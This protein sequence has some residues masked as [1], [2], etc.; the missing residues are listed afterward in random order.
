MAMTGC[1]PIVYGARYEK[2]SRQNVSDA[3]PA[4][5]EVGRTTMADV[6]LTLGD[7]DT[8]AADESW[9]AYVSTYREGGGGAVLILG[10][11]GQ[12]GMLGGASKQM[13]YRR[14]LVRFDGAGLVKQAKLDVV[15][16][17][18]AD[19]F[20]GESVDSSPP[21]FDITS[22]DLVALDLARRL[23]EQGEADVVVFSR[24]E[25]WATHRQGMVAVS[26]T[27]IHFVPSVDDRWTGL[28]GAK[29]ALSDLT[30]AQLAGS[31]FHINPDK[32]QRVVLRRGEVEVGSFVVRDEDSDDSGRTSEAVE[33]VRARIFAA[34]A[35]GATRIQR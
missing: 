22:R 10:G 31:A 3:V 4:F 29:V 27:A 30:D 5:I 15:G 20:L 6:V 18:E 12:V 17:A 26:D 8:V 33:L 28:P 7:P 1:V 25:W 21:C 14:L 19:Y 32:R 11:G 23:E 2:P 34:A 24:A 9:I 35:S 13:L 16:C